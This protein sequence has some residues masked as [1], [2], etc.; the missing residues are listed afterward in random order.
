RL[1]QKKSEWLAVL[2]QE[3]PDIPK[4]RFDLLSTN[5]FGLDFSPD[6]KFLAVTNTDNTIR[7]WNLDRPTPQKGQLLKGH[8]DWV[9]TVAF[10]PDGKKVAT[11]STTVRLWDPATGKE[12][13]LLTDEGEARALA[14]A[15]DGKTLAS[16][17][18]GSSGARLWDLT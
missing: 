7:L 15:S 12:L 17:G 11:G 8:T 18:T 2:D 9:R 10:S 14:F 1:E 16:G 5:P 3:G 6:C 13:A 4:D